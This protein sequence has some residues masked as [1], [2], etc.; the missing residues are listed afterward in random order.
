MLSRIPFKPLLDLALGK[1]GSGKL[2]WTPNTQL[3]NQTG[4]PA[5]SVPLHTNA[6]GLPIGVQLVAPFGGE[7]TLFRVAAQLEQ[8]RPWGQRSPAGLDEI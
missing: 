7:A 4:Q 1:M 6:A 2:A 8:A 5:A 3:F